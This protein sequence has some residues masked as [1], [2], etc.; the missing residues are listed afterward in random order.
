MLDVVSA[1]WRLD[2][3]RLQHRRQTAGHVTDL[4]TSQPSTW[5]K[6]RLLRA[7]HPHLLP[8]TMIRPRLFVR[9]TVSCSYLNIVDLGE[10]VKLPQ[11]SCIAF[12]IPAEG[13]VWSRASGHGARRGS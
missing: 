13:L 2:C 12:R 7:G 10:T 9:C 5:D 6:I 11:L 1:A 4:T 8:K 3:A